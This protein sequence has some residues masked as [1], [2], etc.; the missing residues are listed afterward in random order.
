MAGKKKATKTKA[1]AKPRPAEAPPEPPSPFDA[2]LAGAEAAVRETALHLREVA[3][4]TIEGLREGIYGHHPV[5]LALYSMGGPNTVVCG[6]QPGAGRCLFYLHRIDDPDAPELTL[7]GVGKTARH[8][9]FTG[10]GSV[11]V[12]VIKRL[13]KLS[14]KRL[15]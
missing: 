1:P 13:L 4:S 5:M 8:I 6:I 7:L 2:L 14:A 15:A 11:P 9:E 10:K 12:P 3:L